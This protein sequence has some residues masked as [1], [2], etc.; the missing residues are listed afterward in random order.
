MYLK[1]ALSNVQEY[2]RLDTQGGEELRASIAALSDRLFTVLRDNMQISKHA[3]D[4]EMIADLYSRLANGYMNAPS[5]R[6]TW[7]ESLADFYTKQKRFAESAMCKLHI[8]AMISEYLNIVKPTPGRPNGCVSF[9]NISPNI[10]EETGI[11]E[12]SVVVRSLVFI[13]IN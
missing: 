8:A 10:L 11:R 13:H 2:A 6:I 7:L 5:L 4:P 9:M 1:T 12:T 3:S